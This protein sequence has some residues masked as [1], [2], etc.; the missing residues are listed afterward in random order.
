MRLLRWPL[1]AVLLLALAVYLAAV[2]PVLPIWAVVVSG[3][4]WGGVLVR[5]LRRRSGSIGGQRREVLDVG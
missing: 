5:L 1:L 3:L 2:L 4:L